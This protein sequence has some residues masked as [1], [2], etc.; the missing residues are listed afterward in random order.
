MLLTLPAVSHGRP[1]ISTCPSAI[2]VDRHDPLLRPPAL[3]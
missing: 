2:P 3:S 1:L